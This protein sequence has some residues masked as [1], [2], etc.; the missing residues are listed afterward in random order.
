MKTKTQ[1]SQSILIEEKFS[2]AKSD[3]KKT[4]FIQEA[5]RKKEYFLIERSYFDDEVL[6]KK[7]TEI[8]PAFGISYNKALSLYNEMKNKT[9]QN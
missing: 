1:N 3:W 5:E 9:S 7:E 4:K 2:S 8:I 6:V